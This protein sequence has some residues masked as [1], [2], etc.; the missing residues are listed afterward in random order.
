MKILVTGATGFMGSNITKHLEN[1]GYTV[2]G[3]GRRQIDKPSDRYFICNLDKESLDVDV[4]VDVIVHTAAVSPS[5]ERSFYDYFDNNAIVTMNILRYA[6]QHNVRR[7]IYTGTVSSYGEVNTVLR[8]DSPHNNPNDYGLTKYVA[9]KL[10]RDSGIPYYILILP[11]VVGKGCRNNWIMNTAK[12]LYRGE[13][14]TYYNGKGL[15]N[16]ILEVQDLCNFI[17]V[18]LNEDK[19]G[20]NTYLLGNSEMTTIEDILL[21]FKKKLSSNSQLIDNGK[22]ENAFYLEIDKAVSAGYVSKS[23][24]DTLEII[25]K[26]IS[27][28]FS[29]FNADFGLLGENRYTKRTSNLL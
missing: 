29:G 28:K 24:D 21:F 19:Q 9:E 4:D 25:C 2:F 23:I 22:N 10:I 27:E 14:V 7:I 6:K 16:N 18:L 3:C 1:S 11:G 12:K 20:S 5:S 17:E 8:E 13:D 26:E 15:F